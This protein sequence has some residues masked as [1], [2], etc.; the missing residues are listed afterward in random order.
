VVAFG[1]VPLTNSRA[2]VDYT[3]GKN[4]AMIHDVVSAEYRGDYRIELCFDDGR[5]GVVDFAKY[6]DQGGVF[7]RLR[8]MHY[9][10][11][12]RINEELGVL[13]WEG[14]IDVA[15]E[16]LYADATNTPLPEWMEPE[17]AI[18]SLPSR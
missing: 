11:Q 7:E 6:L 10:R 8:D 16:T 14:N 1:T 3:R 18:S 15:P 2:A 13:T 9:F 17:G 5:R 12:F 4:T